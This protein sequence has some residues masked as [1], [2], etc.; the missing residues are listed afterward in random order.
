ML[1]LNILD[2]NCSSAATKN[3]RT[4]RR[5]G[6]SPESTHMK[7]HLVIPGGLKIRCNKNCACSKTPRKCVKS[8]YTTVF[9]IPWPTYP[10]QKARKRRGGKEKKRKITCSLAGIARKKTHCISV[11]T[12]AKS[13]QQTNGSTECYRSSIHV[14]LCFFHSECVTMQ[15]WSNFQA[16]FGRYVQDGTVYQ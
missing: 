10:A 16:N 9:S 2:K 12:A 13:C 6:I 5:V 11:I 3:I 7:K 15:K 1:F 4:C 8:S 14:R